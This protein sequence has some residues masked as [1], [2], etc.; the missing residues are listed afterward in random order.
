MD[1]I[2]SAL[3]LLRSTHGSRNQ[4]AQYDKFW[5]NLT[6]NS[7]NMTSNYEV[8]QTLNTGGALVIS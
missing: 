4:R 3:C 6:A 5:L 8:S 1:T 7:I 2:F